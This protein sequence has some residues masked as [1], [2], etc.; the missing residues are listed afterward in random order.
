METT[1]VVCGE[2]T[3]L[4]KEGGR[5][6]RRVSKDGVVRRSELMLL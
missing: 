6:A 1:L 5:E 4:S 2:C 3:T